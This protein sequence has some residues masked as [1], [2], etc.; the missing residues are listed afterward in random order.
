[1]LPLWQVICFPTYHLSLFVATMIMF[2]YTFK[3]YLNVNVL[4]IMFAWE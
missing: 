1:M 4:W 2:A 3:T